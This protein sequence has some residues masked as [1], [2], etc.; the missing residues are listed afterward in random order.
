MKALDKIKA[1]ALEDSLWNSDA[2]MTE[3]FLR[4]TMFVLV[5]LLGSAVIRTSIRASHIESSISDY[6]HTSA[7]L[8]LV[9]TMVAI[10]VC[11]MVLYSSNA[12]EN[13][14]LNVAGAFAPIVGFAAPTT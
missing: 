7:R 12:L 10:G 11:L 2:G 3:Q 9:G 4:L 1:T 8:A 5:I 6:F 13:F 14:L